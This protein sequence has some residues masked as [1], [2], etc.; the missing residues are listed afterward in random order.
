MSF[1]F[2]KDNLSLLHPQYEACL[3]PAEHAL[4]MRLFGN[5]LGVTAEKISLFRMVLGSPA[6]RKFRIEAGGRRW[7]AKV[8]TG[9]DGQAILLHELGGTRL[10]ASHGVPSPLLLGSDG[11]ALFSNGDNHGLL[12]DYVEGLYFDGRPEQFLPAIEA[13]VAIARALAT[14]PVPVRADAADFNS[15]FLSQIPGLVGAAIVQGV[16]DSLPSQSASIVTRA[17]AFV[18]ASSDAYGDVIPLHLDF[19]PQNLL[20]SDS[21][22]LCVLDFEWLVPYPVAAGLGFSAYKLIRQGRALGTLPATDASEM[23]DRWI[24]AWNT[25]GPGQRVNRQA[26]R[27]G[28]MLRVL[29]LIWKI[30]DGAIMR[31]DKMFL[32]D[33]SKQVRALTEIP[34]IFTNGHHD[35]SRT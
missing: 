29:Y 28:A 25:C 26:L 8:R 33:L 3:C 32:A 20:F 14:G 18:E 9:T 12:Q 2:K 10:L 15:R 11:G 16:F 21:R 27:V 1:V 19:H 7:F 35:E 5:E 4:V 30:L 6:S 22:L 34:L 13:F 23:L 31:S 24:D 17:L